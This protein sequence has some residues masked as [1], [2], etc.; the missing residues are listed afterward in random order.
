MRSNVMTGKF[1]AV[2]EEVTFA[3]RAVNNLPVAE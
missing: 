1:W 3:P 2:L